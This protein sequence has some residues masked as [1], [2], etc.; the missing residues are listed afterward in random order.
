MGTGTFSKGRKRASPHFSLIPRI[1]LSCTPHPAV[2]LS[3]L[4]EGTGLKPWLD[5]R[6]KILQRCALQDNVNRML[7]T[8]CKKVIHGKSCVFQNPHSESSAQ[9]AARMDRDCHYQ[10]Q[11]RMPKCQMATLL[12]YGFKTMLVQE[13]NQLPR[14]EL[15]EP[16]QDGIPTDNS[17]TC[18]ME[19]LCGISSP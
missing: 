12:S 14:G 3:C 7:S 10:P 2:I 8:I 5:G 15:R 1:I 19:S 11:D 18:T 16:R 13:R 17:S 4:C 6:G 9:C